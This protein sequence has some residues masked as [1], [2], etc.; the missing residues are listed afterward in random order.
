MIKNLAKEYQA[1]LKAFLSGGGETA[2]GK[3]Y[4]LGRQALEQG[5][6]VLDITTVH[7]QSLITLLDRPNATASNIDIIKQASK[8]LAECLSPFEMAQ[9]GFRDSIAALNSMNNMLEDQVA[10]RTQALREKEEL[11]RTLI[12]ISPDAIT[13]TDLHGNVVVCN[14]QSAHLHGYTSSDELVGAFLG[15]F[16][17][18]ED[19]PHINEVAE[20]VIQEGVIGDL[21]YTMIQKNGERIP[22]E[23]RMTLIRDAE[24]KPSGFIGINRNIIERKNI[25]RKLELHAQKQSILTDFGQHALSEM[26]IN[27]LMH[28]TVTLVSQTLNVEFSG[29]WE[30]SPQ[31]DSLTLRDGVGWKEETVGSTTF[32]LDDTSQARFMLLKTEPII[33]DN[34]PDEKRFVPSLFLLEHNIIAC[35]TVIIHGKT[36]PYGTLSACT[37][38]PKQFTQ[39]DANFLQSIANILAMAIDNRRLLET[40]SK[41]R[42]RAEENTERTVRSLAIVSHELRTPL[43]SIKG[44][45]STLLADDV[46]WE[47]EQQRDF[48]QT[49][50]EEAN[51]LNDFIEQILDLSKMNAG[52]FKF[53]VTRQTVQHLIPVNMRQ[54]QGLT[55]QHHLAFSIPEALPDIVADAQRVEQVLANLVENATKYVPVGTTITISAQP[56]ESFIEFS[57]AD[58][59]P[60]IPSEERERVFQPFYR[61]GSKTSNKAKGA[62]LGL[63]ICSRLIEGQGGRIWVD[64]HPGPGTVIKFTLPVASNA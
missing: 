27:V 25:Q 60:G 56:V 17:A 19:L 26:D 6:G 21:E 2:L 10:K 29:L 31:K 12:E 55:P 46:V 49:I 13:M 32:S 61:I 62:G 14:K 23:V 20:T 11:Y 59:G 47:A 63:A 3:A 37:I 41:A 39:E 5:I 52:L 36:Q 38:H 44:F 50:N 33:I 16:V 51:K 8:L 58:E 28:E 30:L 64:E 7:H 9:R 22:V 18:P 1:T 57:V 15:N 42:Q 24:G 40:E 54:L 48:I 43:T 35:I 45:A 4:M 34:L 53:S